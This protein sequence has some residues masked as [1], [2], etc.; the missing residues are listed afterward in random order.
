MLPILLPSV[1]PGADPGVQ[2]VRPQ[3]TISHPP[4][5]RLPLLRPGLRLPS[6]PQSNTAPSPVLSY[7]ACLVTD[8]HRCEQLVQCCYAAFAPSSIW[9]HDLLIESPTLYPLR[10][11]VRNA[12]F[13]GGNSLMSTKCKTETSIENYGSY[14]EVCFLLRS[15]FRNHNT[16]SST[17]DGWP[18]CATID[19][20]R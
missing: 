5:G 15:A 3:V 2:A 19:T 1:G 11:W 7:T 4:S 16:V 9:T 17:E 12:I 18:L 10:T 13:C 8:A 14:P 20:V 6:Q